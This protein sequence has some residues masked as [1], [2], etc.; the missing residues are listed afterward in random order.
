MCSQAIIDLLQACADDE[1]C[2]LDK[3][4]L[5]LAI[6][7]GEIGQLL[8]EYGFTELYGQEGSNSKRKKVLE[9]GHYKEIETYIVGK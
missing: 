7:N 1:K 5:N 9:K 8:S 6:G 3:K 4:I 2:F